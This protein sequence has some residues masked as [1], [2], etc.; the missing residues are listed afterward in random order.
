M[1]S[2]LRR[3]LWNR[4][5]AVLFGL[6]ALG[7][8]AFLSRFLVDEP[9]GLL[10]DA[11]GGLVAFALPVMFLYSALLDAVGPVDQ[12][13]GTAGFFVF[14]YLLAVVAVLAGRRTLTLVRGRLRPATGS[15]PDS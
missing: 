10:G 5:V 3:A 11:L 14:A 6:P 2:G 7:Y 9:A 15:G 12:T 8:V 4:G 13:L 1:R